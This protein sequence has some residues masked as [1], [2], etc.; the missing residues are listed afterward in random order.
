MA[1]K[2]L[3]FDGRG[4]RLLAALAHTNRIAW[5]DPE[6]ASVGGSFP[7]ALPA[8]RL[9]ISD[10]H[11][12]LYVSFANTSLIQRVY[13]SSNAVDLNFNLIGTSAPKAM[14]VIP[15]QPRSL[16]VSFST[17]TNSVTAIFDD[18][19][20]RPNQIT[21]HSFK[22]LAVSRDGNAVFGYDNNTTGG[23]SPDV[24][25]LGVG[26][27]GL[28]HTGNGPS[29]VPWGNNQ[30]MI[31]ASG[32]LVFGNGN[33]ID[34]GSL[35]EQASFTLGQWGHSLASIDSADRIAFLLPNPIYNDP[36]RVRIHA[37]S[38]RQL[39]TEIN[40]G[41]IYSGYG[42]LTYCGADRLAFRAG[43]QI[44]F[45]RSSALP[46]AD[47]VL[48]A[49]ASAP[50]VSVG[51]SINLQ[52]IASNAGPF[53]ISGVA[54]TNYLPIGINLISSHPSQGTVSTNGLSVSASFGT[55]A[56]NAAVTLD[57]ILSPQE[58]AMGW[59]TNW[60]EVGA[61]SLLDPLKQ[62]N[63]IS[64]AFRILPHDS[65]GDQLPDDWELANGLDPNDPTDATIDSDGDGHSNLQEYLAGTNPQDPK[66]VFRV[67]TLEN[68][69][70][71]L[72]ITFTTINGKR[73][74]VEAT[75][76]L[77]DPDWLV[78][79]PDIAGSNQDKEVVVPAIPNNT[80]QFLRVRLK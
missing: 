63:K 4:R 64:V 27:N 16:V 10:D 7:I 37:F 54:L 52:L 56:A 46:S 2:D 72:T 49:T 8:E 69:D 25:R 48:R 45:V 12:Y 62:N 53:A 71:S 43:E 13:L 70:G 34:P 42:S 77:D 5:L 31:F 40:F 68:R 36:A 22:L 58:T 79:V 35:S 15:G 75:S 66:S 78:L 9:V 50:Q 57:L 19:I 29:D 76:S 60:A 1:A 14:A 39:L 3:A 33:V 55:I 74:A 11:Q 65:D 6:T 20:T 18:G 24:F 38:T 21:S 67:V 47:L 44:V 30:E 51:N 28:T 80:V 61:S 73:Y 26:S 17:A 23:D 41:R 32:R 59:V